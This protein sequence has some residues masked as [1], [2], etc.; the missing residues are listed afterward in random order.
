MCVVV[1][2]F[3]LVCLVCVVYDL[4]RCADRAGLCALVCVEWCCVPLFA[5]FRVLR[6]L[7]CIVYLSLCCLCCFVLLCGL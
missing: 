1:V 4:L 2:L 6:V 5:G 3:V 7:C